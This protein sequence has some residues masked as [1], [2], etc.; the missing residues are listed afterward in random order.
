M[1]SNAAQHHFRARFWLPHIL[2]APILLGLVALAPGG[3]L[4]DR[5]P[6]PV[7]IERLDFRHRCDR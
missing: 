1:L 4:G 5:H 2:L 7:G 3:S 6:R